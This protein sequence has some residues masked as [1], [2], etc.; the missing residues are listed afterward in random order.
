VLR[1]FLGHTF[2]LRGKPCPYLPNWT[3]ATE[4]CIG[5]VDGAMFAKLLLRG[6]RRFGHLFFRPVCA[7]CDECKSIRIDPN[8][9]E[10]SGS[11]RR[12]LSKGET[13]LSMK[14]ERPR[15]TDERLSLYERYHKE[16]S[17]TRGWEPESTDPMDYRSSFVECS[18]NYGYEFS[19]YYLDRLVCVALTDIL[20]VGV[21]AVYC[22]YEPEMRSLSLGTYSILR[23]L[24]FAKERGAKRLYLGYCVHGNASLS[25]KARFKPYEVLRGRP[26]L[27]QAPTWE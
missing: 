3:S 14:I 24:A 22:Y 2:V 21:S 13:A 23:Q 6:W 9:F 19:Y 8:R 17:A 18:E 25:Y 11:F 27:D 20:P 26:E 15:V 5:G 12:V 16:R 10:W 1:E 4:Y 7:A